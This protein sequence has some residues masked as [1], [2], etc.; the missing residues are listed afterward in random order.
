M[1]GSPEPLECNKCGKTLKLKF[2]SEGKK[3]H[4]KTEKKQLCFMFDIIYRTFLDKYL[5]TL[6]ILYLTNRLSQK[7]SRIYDIWNSINKKQHKLCKV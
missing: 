5:F 2:S 1:N 4:R 7:K 3:S 6:M